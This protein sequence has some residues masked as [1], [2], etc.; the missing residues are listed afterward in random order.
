M[1]DNS[2]GNKRKLSVAIAMIGEPTI[3]FL[4]EP[5]TGMDP[6]ARRFMWEVINDIVTK[7]EKCSLIL[8]T[9][10][11]EE[12][13]ALCTRIGISMYYCVVL[14]VYVLALLVCVC[15]VVGGVM[16]C[17]GSP[18]HLRT[19][20]G[21]GFQVEIDMIVPTLDEVAH[22]CRVLAE[23]IHA[24]PADTAQRGSLGSIA[25]NSSLPAIEAADGVT[26]AQLEYLFNNQPSEWLK[27]LTRD[28][29][30]SDLLVSLEHTGT[31]A[32]KHLASW[33]LL[34]LR[35]DNLTGFLNDTFGSYILHERQISKMRVELTGLDNKSDPPVERK[36]SGMFGAIEAKRE[37]LCI[38]GYSIS[39]TSLEQIFN[40][41][42][43]QQEEESHL[44]SGLVSTTNK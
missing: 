37:Q 30:A 5:S 8:T 27:R 40:H 20:Y 36:L 14:C 2:G 28:G 42:A 13:E 29:T 35:Y 6:N 15:V 9:H 38:Q 4:D 34:E 7:R 23:M 1:L 17:L 41:F 19:S 10:S 18:Q 44:I 22:Q 11:M 32:M 12:A 25:S 16:R 3:V 33:W 26:R 43:A 24:M 31:V 21:D 39:Q